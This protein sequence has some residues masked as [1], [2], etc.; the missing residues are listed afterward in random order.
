[1]RR[2]R[3]G[4]LVGGL[5]PWLLAKCL[6]P[7]GRLPVALVA[8]GLLGSLASCSPPPPPPPTVVTVSLTATSDVNAAPG[9]PGAPLVVRVYQLSSDAAFS[10]AE[11]FQ[12]FQQDAATL[13]TDLVKKDEYILAPGQSKSATLNPMSTVTEIGIFAAYRSFQTVT[14]RAAVDV[15]PNK[16]TAINV[17]A[18]AKGIVVKTDPPAAL[19]PGS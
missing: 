4:G 17:Q 18:G 3:L 6:T 8:L 16:T 11:F 10:G 1:M 13:K 5:A 9:G 14:W 7:V 15:A 12:L 2:W 19:K